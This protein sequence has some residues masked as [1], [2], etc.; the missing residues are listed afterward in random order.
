MAVFTQAVPRGFRAK[1]YEVNWAFVLLVVLIGSIGVG[2]LYSVAAGS[3][4][5]WAITHAVRFGL[6]FAVM[7]AVVL[8]PPRFWMGVAYPM[9]LAAL[10]LL[11]G[12]ELMGAIVMGAQRWIDIG[13][14]RMQPSEVMKIAL[15]LA[16]ARYYHDLPQE[17]VSSLGGLLVPAAMIGLPT[18]LILK[19]P[20]LGTALLVAA[21][22]GVIVYMA[23]LSWRIIA[24]GA[25][26]VAVG[27]PL[28][29]RYGL[30]EYQRQ[31]ITTFLDPEADPLGA[32]YNI[33][34]SKIALGSGG[35]TG[36]GFMQ[37]TQ[38][39]L[40]YLPEHQT[41]FI[42]TTLGEEWGF[43]GGI[44]VIGL[45]GLL[46][47][48][49]IAIAMS[50]KSVFLRLVVMGITTTLALY[51]FIN[52]AMV[53]GL[54]PV[55]GVP[56]PMISYGGTVMLTVLFGLGLILCAHVHRGAEPPKGAGLFG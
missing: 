46:L 22:G 54:V 41:D 39:Q 8:F 50:C 10:V 48:N 29:I 55:V 28:A 4:T 2:M 30:E 45:Y 7:L 56:L 49:C 16:L 25:V 38:S 52:V 35:F 17:K 51:V 14:I 36:K 43:V 24:G 31:R 40:N 20:D 6:G 18:V 15:V 44:F 9:Y 26:A 21:T 12:V 32:G 27:V 13:P 3:W 33:I 19:Q 42:F 37:G 11:I 34:Q 5:P 1:L 53:M 23:G 47:A